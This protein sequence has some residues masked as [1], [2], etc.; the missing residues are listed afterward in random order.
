MGSEAWGLG[1]GF[2]VWDLGFLGFGVQAGFGKKGCRLGC[3]GCSFREFFQVFV[4]GG[5]GVRITQWERC[6]R[7]VHRVLCVSA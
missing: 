7:R 2:K 5:F 1:I 6:S 3:L 4:F